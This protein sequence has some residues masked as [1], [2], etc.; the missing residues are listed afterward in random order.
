MIKSIIT[1]TTKNDHYDPVVLMGV[2]SYIF[3]YVFLFTFRVG[4]NYRTP[5]ASQ[6]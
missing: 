1:H 5:F 6:L 3:T 2:F 4:S